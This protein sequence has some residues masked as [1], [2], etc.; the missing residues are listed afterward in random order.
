MVVV[1]VGCVY[2]AMAVIIMASLWVISVNMP[3]SD[4]L[5][6][7]KLAILGISV[8]AVFCA[9]YAVYYFAKA[10]GATDV[11]AK[12]AAIASFAGVGASTLVTILKGVQNLSKL[13]VYTGQAGL[14]VGIYVTLWSLATLAALLTDG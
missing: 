3:P 14:M 10:I 1:G 13:S 9:A 2:S 4:I 5:P 8:F 12:L 7:E 11:G 6:V